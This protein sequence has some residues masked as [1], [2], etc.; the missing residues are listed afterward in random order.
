[1]K[2]FVDNIVIKNADAKAMILTIWDEARRG[3]MTEEHL[4][5]WIDSVETALD[6]SQRLNFIRWPIINQYVHQNPRLWGSFQAEVENVRTFM[7]ERIAWMDKRLNYTYADN[8]ITDVLVDLTQPYRV[9]SL[10]GQ[11][12]GDSLEGLRP[13]IYVV[14]QGEAAKKVVV[15]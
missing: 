1:M 8:G 11:P 4:V 13:G 15:R 12:S 9:Y 7:K 14:R 2:S 3:G 10:S 6:Q 5:A